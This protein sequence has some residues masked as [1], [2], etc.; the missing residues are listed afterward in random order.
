MSEMENASV[1]RVNPDEQADSIKEKTESGG[2]QDTA[3]DDRESM[4][5]ND[6][7]LDTAEDAGKSGQT[8]KDSDKSSQSGNKSD[9]GSENKS[10][11]GP[12][13]KDSD[14]DMESK[15]EGSDSQ[16]N[17]SAGVSPDGESEDDKEEKKKKKQKQKLAR[18]GASSGAQIGVKALLAAKLAQM[19]KL[20]L[21]FMANVA[22]AVGG[23]FSAIFGAIWH[24]I[25][26]FGSMIAGFFASAAGAVASA[27]GISVTA[28][29][30]GLL[31][32]S[33]FII[34][35]AVA[36]VV[37]LSTDSSTARTDVPAETDCMSGVRVAADELSDEVD[38]EA[39]DEALKANAR[40]IYFAYHELGLTD[41]MIAGA[42][43]NFQC[44]SSID[45][46]SV[47]GTYHDG[48]YNIN[49]EEHLQALGNDP[50]H[51]DMDKVSA[52]TQAKLGKWAT[53]GSYYYVSEIGKYICGFGLGQWTGPTA[54]D[55]LALADS[56]GMAWYDLNF[57]IIYSIKG[58]RPGFFDDWVKKYNPENGV[59][60]RNFP[61][62][63]PQN[64][65]KNT[66]QDMATY[67]SYFFE[68]NSTM[69]QDLRRKYAKQWVLYMSDWESGRTDA[70][71]ANAQSILTAAQATKIEAAADT[72]SNKSQGC[73]GAN[74]IFA[75]GNGS[76]A[77]A[78]ASFAYPTREESVGNNGTTLYQNVVNA[79]LPEDAKKRLYQSCDRCV[80]A[81]VR[82]AGAD[83]SFPNGDTT[84]QAQY[85]PTA[86]DKWQKVEDYNGD[87]S[88]LQPGDVLVIT[89]AER[90]SDH[91]HIV[92]YAGS[93]AIMAAHKEVKDPNVTIVAASYGERSAGCQTFY[94]EL[95]KYTAYRNI[96]PEASSVYKNVLSGSAPS[97]PSGAVPAPSP[98]STEKP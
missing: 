84:R 54:K 17:E 57:Q 12:G 6:T 79:V 55:F 47:E 98:S 18:S 52:W 25:Q 27:V 33:C 32:I 90:H 9:S 45:P 62:G 11:K 60:K 70:D 22:S 63:A 15:E 89:A 76:I 37:G 44:E 82:W 42:L 43:A 96:Q 2:T 14:A 40:T 46:T 3:S 19:M 88:K 97:G 28:A 41:N 69:A 10:E 16:K 35:S 56:Q 91:G 72:L 61:N 75:G 5:S 48:H 8:T 73:K 13:D 53:P 26:A 36:G 86:T 38:A 68:G 64:Q 95:K 58:Y 39:K 93:E 85:L 21:L 34:I 94:D 50:A 59:V 66:P 49:G 4:S 78:A 77:Q 7:A 83:D 87:M 74:D 67:F 24:G 31:G 30:T 1:P 71:T 29:T 65:F 20:M 81:A 92:I 23:I 80:A 51:P